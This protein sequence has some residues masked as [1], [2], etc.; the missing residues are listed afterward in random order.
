MIIEINSVNQTD[1]QFLKKC[2]VSNVVTKGGSACMS[3]F[4]ITNGNTRFPIVG[5][6][7][8]CM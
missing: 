8:P 1:L 5:G 3:L 4:K 7:T 6:S 2:N